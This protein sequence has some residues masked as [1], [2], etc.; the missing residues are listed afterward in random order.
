MAT[1]VTD[2][3]GLSLPA[4]PFLPVLR[5]T[6]QLDSPWTLTSLA[7]DD[8]FVFRSTTGELSSVHLEGHRC[9]T[10]YGSKPQT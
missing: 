9:S 5:K 1:G 7:S 4:A 6:G 2:F 8:K 3:R 10:L